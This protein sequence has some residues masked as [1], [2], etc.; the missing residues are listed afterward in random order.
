MKSMFN[1]DYYRYYGESWKLRRASRFLSDH[2][3]WFL[4]LFRKKQA[5]CPPVIDQIISILLQQI[6]KKY[7]LEIPWNTRIDK[8][9][10]IGHPYNITINPGAKLGKNINIHKGATIGQENRGSRK[11]IPTIGNNVWIG[12]NATLVGNITI[13]NDVLITPNSYVNMDIPS[14]SIVIGNPGRIIPKENA[15]EGYIENTV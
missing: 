10:Y 12:V 1:E 3:L 5:G 13:G 11:G 2:S 14:H 7:G 8:G 9:L 6:R 15:T 4:F